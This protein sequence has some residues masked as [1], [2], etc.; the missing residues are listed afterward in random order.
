MKSA[1]RDGKSAK[2]A[3]AIPPIFSDQT[4]RRA[5]MRPHAADHNQVRPTL[6]ANR[7]IQFLQFIRGD[8]QSKPVDGRIRCFPRAARLD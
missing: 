2:R 8:A 3:R 6:H 7:S 5:V 4:F 1:F